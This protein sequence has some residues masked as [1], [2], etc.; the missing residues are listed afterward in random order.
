LIIQN[1]LN[2]KNSVKITKYLFF[3]MI[4]YAKDVIND[5]KI[6]VVYYR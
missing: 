5:V 6:R 2:Y 1:I 3:I 4:A